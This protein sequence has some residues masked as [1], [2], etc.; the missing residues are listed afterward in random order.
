MIKTVFPH[1]WFTKE[2]FFQNFVKFPLFSDFDKRSL[3]Y[4]EYQDLKKKYCD[5]NEIFSVQR[6]LLDYCHTDVAV[7]LAG[8]SK[9]IQIVYDRFNLHPLD[10][11][12]TLSS[13][14]WKLYKKNFI[15]DNLYAIDTIDIL[16]NNSKIQYEILYYIK[17]LL[18]GTKFELI[19]QRE[20]LSQVNVNLEGKNYCVDAIIINKETN[21]IV[22]TIETLGCYWHQHLLGPNSPC[23]RNNTGCSE[24]YWSTMSRI[25]KI[26]RHLPVLRVWEC[27][28]LELRDRSER[29]TALSNEFRYHLDKGP[30]LCPRAALY[31]GRTE[32]IKRH[33]V[34]QP[35]EIIKFEDVVSLY[36]SVQLK[37]HYP[38]GPFT[39][40]FGYELPKISDFIQIMRNNPTAGAALVTV[41][42]P[43]RL[44]LPTLPFKVD[45]V[46]CFAL[47]PK[48]AEFLTYPCNHTKEERYICGAYTYV[49]LLEAV[50]SGYT[51]IELH[52]LLF[53]KKVA[54]IFEKAIKT[55]A[56]LKIGYSGWP[57][58]VKTDQQKREYVESFRA[59]G[60]ELLLQDMKSNKSCATI[61][62]IF[63][64]G[65]WGRLALNRSRYKSLGIAKTTKE[66]IALY[67]SQ[68][69]HK[70]ENLVN[71]IKSE[72]VIY[73]YSEE[74]PKKNADC[75]V[76]VA[77]M[78]TSL[79]R[80]VLLKR[81]RSVKGLLY[82][83]TDSCI[84]VAQRG[85]AEADKGIGH[86]LGSWSCEITSKFSSDFEIIEFIALAPKSY[87]LKLKNKKTGEIKII[88][89]LKGVTVKEEDAERNFEYL[90]KLVY[91][92]EKGID[93]PV[94]QFHIDAKAAEIHYKSMVKVLRDTSK[95]RYFGSDFITSKPWGYI[96]E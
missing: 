93:M 18:R 27:S 73:E 85:D 54:K 23:P 16:A 65:L 22:T 81:M 56:A 70:L 3:T 88:I 91:S 58:H 67:K 45:N 2:K 40:Q 47:C 84:Y 39:V 48:C 59:Q 90:K 43:A 61:W 63:L 46:L 20:K 52:E 77:A 26:E 51:I 83:D 28:W 71:S 60:I 35:G 30:G 76:L 25:K 21:Q 78:V 31:G 57:A 96:E 87:G 29:I 92:E 10:N 38:V 5:S 79:A 9:F 12:V 17:T 7:L 34:A 72:K 68:G 37:S 86:V 13:V 55:I 15:P 1:G 44:E 41:S 50:D 11:T 33:Y 36:P 69:S 74:K 42:P 75:N 89:K 94:T 95:K 80:R 32:V 14:C 8:F 53:C 62:K 66:L 24:K 49:E 6:M 64:N 4:T 82:A 19:S